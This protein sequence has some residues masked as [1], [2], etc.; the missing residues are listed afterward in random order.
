MA[1]TSP[2]M[3]AANEAWQIRQKPLDKAEGRAGPV[4]PR[5]LLPF[6]KNR[7]GEAAL[8]IDPLWIF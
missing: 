8:S 4:C 2:A 5:A 3:T 1:G 6:R 7:Y